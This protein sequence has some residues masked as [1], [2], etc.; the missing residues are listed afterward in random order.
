MHMLLAVH[1]GG[2]ASHVVMHELMRYR[3]HLFKHVLKGFDFV[4]DIF[5]VPSHFGQFHLNS[6]IN[7]GKNNDFDGGFG[8]F[9][10][11]HRL[12]LATLNPM[13]SGFPAAFASS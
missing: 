7:S 4:I 11:Q 5:A 12:M 9:A 8:L 10:D 1:S 6:R 2:A 13:S 3:F